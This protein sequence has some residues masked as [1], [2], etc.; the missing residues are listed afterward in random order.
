MRRFIAFWWLCVRK[1]FWGNTAFANDW[2]WL[3]G[4]P[5]TAALLWALGY[6]YA[7]FSGRVEVTLA[8]GALGALAAAF[9]AF[10]ITWIIA[11]VARLL[12]APVELYHCEKDRAD[13]LEGLR[14]IA[15]SVTRPPTF[16]LQFE[17]LP[18]DEDKHRYGLHPQIAVCRIIV[19]NL[20]H[21]HIEDC[22][23]VVESFGPDAPINSGALLLP[24]ERSSE[25]PIGVFRLAPTEKRYFKFLEINQEL[26][27]RPAFGGDI[28]WEIAI[29]SDQDGVGWSAVNEHRELATGTRYFVTLA[30]HGK[31]ASSRR[32]NL[33]VDI[34]SSTEISVTETGV[35]NE[36]QEHPESEKVR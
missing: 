18:F 32:I 3:V 20:E 4:Y 6:F 19:E 9:I 17:V 1:A 13:Q 15:D 29:K 27:S 14:Q 26:Y 7:E 33:T 35:S 31:E 8:N 36:R 12:D 2:Q 34:V 25:T 5:A 23:I 21:R 22:R 30:V 16:D 11:F 28:K 24:D 10:V